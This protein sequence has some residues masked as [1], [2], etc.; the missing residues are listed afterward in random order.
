MITKI[1]QNGHKTLAISVPSVTTMGD[2]RELR[3]ALS[4]M[5]ESCLASDDG[6]ENTPS[7]AIYFVLQMIRE[8][9]NDIEKGGGHEE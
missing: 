9:T 7:M 6:K 3:D 5:L 8:L 4:D 2:V 1:E